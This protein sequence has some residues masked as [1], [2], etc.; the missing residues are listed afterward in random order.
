MNKAF[1]PFTFFSPLGLVVVCIVISVAVSCVTDYVKSN[2]EKTSRTTPSPVPWGLLVP[3]IVMAGFFIFLFQNNG[4]S[5]QSQ[6]RTQLRGHTVGQDSA[7][8]SAAEAKASNVEPVKTKSQHRSKP[9]FV[10][11]NKTPNIT[12]ANGQAIHKNERP[13]ATEVDPRNK[14]FVLTAR[15]ANQKEAEKQLLQQARQLLGKITADEWPSKWQKRIANR[16][17]H[18]KFKEII[19]RRIQIE[20]GTESVRVGDKIYKNSAARVSWEV[21]F[22]PVVRRELRQHASVQSA[23]QITSFI[24]WFMVIPLAITIYLRLNNRTNGQYRLRLLLS[25]IVLIVLAGLFFVA[26]EKER[27]DARRFQNY[28]TKKERETKTDY[29]VETVPLSNTPSP[30]QTEKKRNTIP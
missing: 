25:A 14:Q 15:G 13:F 16:I 5:F 30:S 10:L 3:F 7:P 26:G 29:P 17:S 18:K 9:V 20:H 1:L 12:Y 11:D 6:S 19:V 24:G 28:E 27:V 21:N 4:E 2:G 22:S 23:W 8:D